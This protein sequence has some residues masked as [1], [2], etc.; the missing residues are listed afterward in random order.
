MI[1][2]KKTAAIIGVLVVLG[3]IAVG[4]QYFYESHGGQSSNTV[5]SSTNTP[6]TVLSQNNPDFAQALAA[7]SQHNYTLSK[8]YYEAAL[9]TTTDPVQQA[10]I[11]YDIASATEESGDYADA[12]QMY[13]Q[14]AADTSNYNFVRAYAVQQIG[15]I[16]Y[17]Y[18][19]GNESPI[20]AATFNSAPYSSFYATSSISLS[21]KNLFQYAASIYPLGQS[22]SRIAYWYAVNIADTLHSTTTPEAVSELSS[23]NQ[24]IQLANQDSA[25]AVLDPGSQRMVPSVYMLEGLSYEFLAPLGVASST[26]I[27]AQFSQAVRLA[28]SFGYA[29]YERYYYASYLA[30]AYG[31]SRESDIQSLLAPFTSSNAAEIDPPVSAFFAAT[32]SDSSQNVNKQSMIRLANLDPSFKT[33]LL[34]L[35]WENSDF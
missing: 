28:D 7:Q 5:Y 6:T 8:Q 9:Q 23:M 26:E 25:R 34:S 11:E 12:I 1:D 33:Y 3:I 17:T 20:V 30:R 14:I 27:E 19:G 18:L 2:I 16:Y 15:L 24:A 35:G 29:G 13:K 21:Y 32:E 10:Q 4:V 22:E 31:S